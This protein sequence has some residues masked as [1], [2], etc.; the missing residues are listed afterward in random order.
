[1]EKIKFTIL[2]TAWFASGAASYCY[3]WTTTHDLKVS[4]VPMIVLS[5]AC[6]PL[7]FP[8]G[9]LIHGKPILSDTVLI[10]KR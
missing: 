1:M 6:G 9:W 4:H 10:P 5:G 7:S 3:W 2:L 8:I